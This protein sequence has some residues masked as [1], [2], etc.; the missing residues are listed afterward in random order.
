MKKYKAPTV[1]CVYFEM[2]VLLSS[3]NKNPLD[4]DTDI[5]DTLGWY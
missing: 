2:D 5:R 3:G 4:Y 1:K